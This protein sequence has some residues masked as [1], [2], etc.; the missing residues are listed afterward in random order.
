MAG[1]LRGER[2]NLRPA[3][4]GTR[5]QA[6]SQTSEKPVPRT[7]AKH[8]RTQ[9]GFTTFGAPYLFY[10]LAV[11][12]QVALTAAWY[13]KWLVH[14]RLRPEEY[15]G[16]VEV[17]RAG[18]ARYPIPILGTPPEGEIREIARRMGIEA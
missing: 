5:P 9:S 11:V 2:R 17:H 8:S 3:G 1:G 16:R 18:R 13:Q 12:T 15:A 6:T 4:F 14:R 7:R 10:L